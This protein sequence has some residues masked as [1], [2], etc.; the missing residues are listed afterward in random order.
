[1]SVSGTPSALRFQNWKA[2]VSARIIGDEDRIKIMGVVADESLDNIGFILDARDGNAN[3]GSPSKGTA[4]RHGW[5]SCIE[6]CSHVAGSIV[7]TTHPY[8]PFPDA[9]CSLGSV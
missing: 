2:V 4:G 6:A 8:Y 7:N 5:P 1:M 3:H 9:N